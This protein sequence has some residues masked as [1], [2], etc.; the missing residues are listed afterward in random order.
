MAETRRPRTLETL[1]RALT[2]IETIQD[3]NGARV[4]ELA[5][6]LDLPQSTV[7]GYLATL[8]LKH[9]LVKN[10]D[11]YDI[12]LKFLNVGGYVTAREPGYDF[13][14]EKVKE[15]ARETGERAQFIV[16]EYGRGTYIHT[17]TED[18]A[19]KIDARI[20]KESPLHASAAGKA[21]LSTFSRGRV[22][23]II[24]QWGL[25]QLTENTITDRERLFDELETTAE[26]GFSLNREESVEGLHAVGAPIMTPDGQCF[27]S[28][29]VSAPS[30]RFQGE[31]FTEDIPFLVLGATNDIELRLAYP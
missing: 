30:N 24:D 31:R 21:I 17:E 5:D 23:E 19:V 10:G 27:G 3:L 1:E 2:V 13:A 22:E 26:R 12:G 7:H 16:E 4:S 6:E 20:G 9:Y 15:L 25:S 14:R 29:S 28:L 8:R 18:T 11:E